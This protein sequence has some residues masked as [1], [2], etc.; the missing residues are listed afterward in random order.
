MFTNLFYGLNRPRSRFHCE[1]ISRC[2]KRWSGA[3]RCGTSRS[4]T[5][6]PALRLI[7]DERNIDKFDRVFA[8]VFKGLEAVSGTDAVEQQEIPEEWLRKMAEK[9]L[10]EEEK[11]GDRSAWRLGKADGDAE[12]SVSRSRRS[13]IRA[14]RNGSALPARRPL[15]PMATI[16]K[17]SASA[18][19]KVATVLR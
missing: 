8:Q 17:A 12:E 18:K 19:R 11:K 7:K 10:T 1:N 9:H 3:W 5:S 6:S 16:P 4:S 14:V 15:G 2:W 13:A